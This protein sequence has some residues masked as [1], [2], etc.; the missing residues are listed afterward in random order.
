MPSQIRTQRIN[1]RA[2]PQPHTWRS[3]YVRVPAG[4]LDVQRQLLEQVVQ[5]AF[6]TLG[7][8]HLDVHVLGARE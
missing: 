2:L 1:D 5:F 4:S 6:D 3:F 7:A 8:D